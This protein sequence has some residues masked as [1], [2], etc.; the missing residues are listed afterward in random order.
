VRWEF[1][2]RFIDSTVVISSFSKNNR[3]R[4]AKTFCFSEAWYII[5]ENRLTFLFHFIYHRVQNSCFVIILPNF[6]H[7]VT[8]RNTAR[9]GENAVL[10]KSGQYL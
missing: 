10:K 4:K 3:F 7:P 5:T 9:A 1:S 6:S 8:N 2:F